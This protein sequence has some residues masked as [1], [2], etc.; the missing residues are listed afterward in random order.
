M[1]L[2]RIT[3]VDEKRLLAMPESGMGYQILVHPGDYL[4]VLNASV[5][6]KFSEYQRGTFDDTN[7]DILTGD[8]VNDKIR[9]L[10]PLQIEANDRLAFHDFLASEYPP[11]VPL[12][13][14]KKVITPSA[15][16]LT[17]GRPYSYYRFCSFHKDK[18]VDALG[19]FMPGTYATTFADLHFVPSGF[20]AVGRYALPNPA[21][22]R[23]VFQ[24][25]SWDKP[26]LM[27]A[28]TPNYGQ[29][30]GG[31]EVYFRNGARN[32]PGCSFPITLG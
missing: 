29:A 26:T 28:A 32:S 7:F 4:L 9:T 5:V 25:V 16:S 18:R 22:A 21:S 2:Y 19:N 17:T 11:V 27:G 31:V 23:Y 3:E 8:P 10:D 1:K 24:I 12:V 13:A 30:G 15:L 6:V 14:S 20:A